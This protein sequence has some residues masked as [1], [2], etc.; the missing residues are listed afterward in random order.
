[1][2]T[3]RRRELI[4]MGIGG[5][6]AVSLGAAFWNDLFGEAQS[7]PLRRGPGYGPLGPPDEHGIRLPEGFS[8][9]IVAR[10]DE[11]VAATGYRW[12]V[13]S[14]GSAEAQVRADVG[15]RERV[16]RLGGSSVR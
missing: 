4:G 15:I 3:V 8:S 9:R 14:D 1:M 5:V 12:H 11:P 10:G 7:R 6:A 2:R 13:A 16:S